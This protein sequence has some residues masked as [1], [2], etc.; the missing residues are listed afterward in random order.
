MHWYG[1]DL[2]W[3]YAE[4]LPGLRRQTGC[5]HHAWDI[6]HDALLRY[7]LTRTRTQIAQPHAYLRTVIGA[8]L[9]DHHREQRRFVAL[10]DDAGASDT[11]PA[12]PSAETVAALR[13]RL[14]I[15]QRVLDALPPRCREVFW[16]F[17]IESHTQGEIAL[18]LGISVNMVERHVMRALVD[19]RTVKEQLR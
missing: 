14:A 19:L 13:Q 12:E 3:A 6:L 18:K 1:L 10:P 4:L 7:A 17:R 9:V 16:L 5:L 2:R 15:L 11:V 8:V